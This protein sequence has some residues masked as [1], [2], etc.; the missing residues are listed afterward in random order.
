MKDTT[1]SSPNL[2]L[3]TEIISMQYSHSKIE[4]FEYSI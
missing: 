4:D 1:F 2:M 3:L